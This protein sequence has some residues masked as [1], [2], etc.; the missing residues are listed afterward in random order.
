M[1]HKPTVNQNAVNK[2]KVRAWIKDQGTQPTHRLL[3]FGVKCIKGWVFSV[4][5]TNYKKELG[6]LSRK[7]KL[8]KRVGCL[9]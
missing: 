3:Y 6:V 9:V 4:E 7:H 1:V 8:Q 2:E 5:S